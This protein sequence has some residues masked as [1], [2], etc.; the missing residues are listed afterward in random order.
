M[1]IQSGRQ[2]KSDLSD[3]LG[4]L[5]DHE[6]SGNPIVFEKIQK[7]VVDLYG[8]WLSIPETSRIF[9]LNYGR[10]QIRATVQK[11]FRGRTRNQET[12]D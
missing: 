5:V 1:K 4:I 7:A 12:Y 8:D 11:D 10:W 6:K 9:I 3:V 2:Y